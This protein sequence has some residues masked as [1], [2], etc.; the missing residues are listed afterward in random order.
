M[1]TAIVSKFK[2][3]PRNKSTWRAMWF[4]IS[5]FL[6]FPVVRLLIGVVN[7]VLGSMS[8]SRPTAVSPGMLIATSSLGLAI[9]GLVLSIRAFRTGERSW[10]VWLGLVISALVTLFWVFMIFGEFIFPH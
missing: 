8:D 1:G 9:T 10:V 5:S 7:R 2:E 3:K 4:S 6:V